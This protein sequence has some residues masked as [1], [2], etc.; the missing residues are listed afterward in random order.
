MEVALALM[1][2]S[3][4]YKSMD[5][6]LQAKYPELWQGPVKNSEKS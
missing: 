5:H 6:H 4:R 1:A 3:V 2:E